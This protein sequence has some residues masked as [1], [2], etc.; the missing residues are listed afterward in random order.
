MI[1]LT[2]L[3]WTILAAILWSQ[4]RLHELTCQI[5]TFS[6]AIL[7]LR[8]EVRNSGTYGP[9]ASSSSCR[10]KSV[11]NA[12][13]CAVGFVGITNESLELFRQQRGKHLR[14]KVHNK[15]N[16]SAL[17]GTFAVIECEGRCAL[18]SDS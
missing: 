13:T 1:V 4:P 7:E 15:Q 6:I 2:M 16:C 3:P 14:K 17:R 8:D 10:D 5:S 18:C 9:E 11:P 12:P